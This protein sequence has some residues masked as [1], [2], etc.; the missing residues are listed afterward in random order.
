MRILIEDLLKWDPIKQKPKGK[1][2]VGT[3]LSCAPADEEQG[4]KTLHSHWQ[5]WMEE[6]SQELRD[7]IFDRDTERRFGARHKF[8]RLV[9]SLMSASFGNDFEVRHDCEP[10]IIDEI[11]TQCEEKKTSDDHFVDREE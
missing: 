7:A 3:V 11:N 6:L 4:R 9:D 2:I 10:S 8:L 5:I 1:G